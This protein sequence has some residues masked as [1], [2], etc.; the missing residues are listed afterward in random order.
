MPPPHVMSSL[1]VCGMW[2]GGREEEKETHRCPPSRNVTYGL[3]YI[4]HLLHLPIT[5]S[6]ITGTSSSPSFTLLYGVITSANGSLLL[7]NN[8]LL[9]GIAFSVHLWYEKWAFVCGVGG[10]TVEEGGRLM[11]GGGRR[12]EEGSGG[13]DWRFRVVAT[14]EMGFGA[15]PAGAPMDIWENW[16]V[17]GLAACP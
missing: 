5:I 16:L 11:G 6:L 12:R 17:S 9:V 2:I 15:A 8:E 7:F 10:R 4:L 1:L 13:V 3:I 14:R